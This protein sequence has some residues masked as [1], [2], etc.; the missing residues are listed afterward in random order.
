MKLQNTDTTNRLNTL[1]QTKNTLPSQTVS[2][3]SSSAAVNTA[4]KIRMFEM[5]NRYTQGR[6]MRRGYLEATQPKT[7]A[8]KSIAM[9]VPMNR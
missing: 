2:L 1:S 9:N 6:N 4:Q 7:G 3:P 5:K 8:A